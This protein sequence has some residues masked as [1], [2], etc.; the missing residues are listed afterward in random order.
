MAEAVQGEADAQAE[1]VSSTIPLTLHDSPSPRISHLT[2]PSLD[3]NCAIDHR[4][5]CFV[6]ETTGGAARYDSR[7]PRKIR[8]GKAAI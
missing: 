3:F 7:F 1:H 4:S 5:S 2:V 8:Q 6:R